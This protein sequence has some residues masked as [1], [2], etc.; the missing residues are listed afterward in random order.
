MKQ[1][2]ASVFCA[3]EFLR[4]LLDE[5]H[6]RAV[7][8]LSERIFRF[9]RATLEG[10]EVYDRYQV[11]PFQAVVTDPR[12]PLPFNDQRYPQMAKILAN[13]R[14]RRAADQARRRDAARR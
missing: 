2:R 7:L 4:E 10:R 13:D 6:A 5:Q 12:L 14:H 3:R 1:L 11:D 9:A 8:T